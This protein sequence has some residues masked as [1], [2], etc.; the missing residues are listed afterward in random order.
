MI[1]SITLLSS[2]KIRLLIYKPI[3]PRFA[4][5]REGSSRELPP[6]ENWVTNRQKVQK[7][8]KRKFPNSYKKIFHSKMIQRTFWAV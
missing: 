1:T 5:E 6:V 8:V 4:G 7:D 3:I 2:C